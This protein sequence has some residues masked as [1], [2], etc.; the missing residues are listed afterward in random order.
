MPV[1]ALIP[2]QR[3]CPKPAETL[4]TPTLH[5]PALNLLPLLLP[6]RLQLVL[7][8]V[9]PA[10]N[11]VERVVRVLLKLLANLL[12]LL[13]PPQALL[14]LH[15]VQSPLLEGG[16]GRFEPSFWVAVYGLLRARRY[17]QRIEGV[18]YAGRVYG[19]AS[20]RRGRVGVQ[21]GEVEAASLLLRSFGVARFGR[22]FGQ[23]GLLFGG[24]GGL[25]CLL[26]GGF[27]CFRGGC[28]PGVDVRRRL[29]W[30]QESLGVMH[31][32]CCCPCCPLPIPGPLLWLP[33]AL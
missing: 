28:L 2:K 32:S 24:E 31:T 17:G 7:C 25:L 18:V 16:V 8:A 9:E 33:P 3:R 22:G 20:L 1:I 30:L 27:R 11:L 4:R 5:Q 29:W 26:P 15:L 6:E 12:N 23:G 10:R 14:V 13:V 21:L 19:G